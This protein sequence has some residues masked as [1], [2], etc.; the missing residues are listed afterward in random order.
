[1]EEEV[2]ES[3]CCSCHRYYYGLEEEKNYVFYD[4]SYLG[5]GYL[6]VNVK[7]GKMNKFLK[8]Y[9]TN[10][11]GFPSFGIRAYS[12]DAR[13]NSNDVFSSIEF[14]F[15]DIEDYDN[16]LYRC[17]THLNN[18]LSGKRVFSVDPVREG[19]NNFKLDSN[20]R[21]TKITLLKDTYDGDQHPTD[22]ID[23]LIGDQYTC[24]HYEE[25]LKF[26]TSLSE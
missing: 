21:V 23:I 1:M 19:K 7:D 24:K 13:E 26:Y 5:P 11:D 2:D 4:E 16:D 22:Y 8:I 17:F 10:S 12:V 18:D 20:P 6:I 25:I 14:T 15:R 9:E 3:N